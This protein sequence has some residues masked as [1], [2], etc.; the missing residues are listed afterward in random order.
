MKVWVEFVVITGYFGAFRDIL[1]G[2]TKGG[3]AKIR[4]GRFAVVHEPAM[5]A[6]KNDVIGLLV[7]WVGIALQIAA[8]RFNGGI[9][10]ASWKLNIQ[11]RHEFP[12]FLAFFNRLT[13]KEPDAV[14][15]AQPDIVFDEHHC[16]RSLL[17]QAEPQNGAKV[18]DLR[19]FSLAILSVTCSPNVKSGAG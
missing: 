5:I 10:G 3:H 14:N 13:R 17:R 7:V 1:R 6:I 19:I 2:D 9:E 15:P 4:I 18:K 8:D 12:Y 16:R 11:P